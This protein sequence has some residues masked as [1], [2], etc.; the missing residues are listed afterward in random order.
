ML[1]YFSIPRHLNN[2]N[3]TVKYKFCAEAKK[4]R[5]NSYNFWCRSLNGKRPY[6]TNSNHKIVI[7]Q[8]SHKVPPNS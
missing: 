7:I 5:Q 1:A 4:R 8:K 3:L 2:I 6:V